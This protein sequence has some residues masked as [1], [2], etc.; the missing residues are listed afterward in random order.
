VRALLKS[1]IAVGGGH[2]VTGTMVWEAN[3]A[4]GYNVHIT[5][6]NANT[7]VD[8]SNVLVTQCAL[9][10]FQYSSQTSQSSPPLFGAAATAPL[11]LPEEEP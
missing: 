3:D 10:H 6:R 5:A 11:P 7:G 4:R 2:T 8:A 1:P 9:H